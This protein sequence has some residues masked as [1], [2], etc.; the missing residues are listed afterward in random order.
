MSL[1]LKNSATSL[2]YKFIE[3]IWFEKYPHMYNLFSF[4]DSK[5]RIF[6][7]YFFFLLLIC[8]IFTH[9]YGHK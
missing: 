9:A 8:D 1:I 2:K 3:H 5:D 6:K 7:Y 4:N